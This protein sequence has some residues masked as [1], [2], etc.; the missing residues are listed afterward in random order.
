MDANGDA[1][2]TWVEVRVKHTEIATYAMPRLQL[3]MAGKACP[4][5]VVEHLIDEHT[6]GAYAVL[7]FQAGC[8]QAFDAL[9]ASYS[10][11]FDIDPQHKG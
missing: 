6:D 4:T 5:R 10:L 2:I 9:Q 1:E 11:F 8:A 7:H 3:A